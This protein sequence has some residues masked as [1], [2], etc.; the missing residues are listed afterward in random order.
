MR[1]IGYYVL[2]AKCNHLWKCSCVSDR[3]PNEVLEFTKNFHESEKCIF[4]SA[5]HTQEITSVEDP[6]QNQLGLRALSEAVLNRIIVANLTSGKKSS[7]SNFS[8]SNEDITGTVLFSKDD[9]LVLTCEI[10]TYEG[11]IA[12]IL[13]QGNPTEVTAIQRSIKGTYMGLPISRHVLDD[14]E[15]DYYYLS[16]F[17][18]QI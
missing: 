13:F 8:V 7:L 9:A 4:C 6:L 14:A 12:R 3:H 11:K 1:S 18:G 2:C 10:N 17:I 16:I 5:F 15:Q